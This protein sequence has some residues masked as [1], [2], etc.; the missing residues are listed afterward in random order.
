MALHPGVKGRGS[1]I[2]RALDL[3]LFDLPSLRAALVK[4]ATGLR[5][6]APPGRRGDESAFEV[7][8]VPSRDDLR[9]CFTLRR[10]VYD[11]MGYLPEAVSA[12]ASNLELDAFDVRA[13]HFMATHVP[14]GDLAGTMRLV[15]SKPQEC[16]DAVC[17][18]AWGRNIGI[19]AGE[20][21]TRF[22]HAP[23]FWPLPI[24]ASADF[25]DKWPEMLERAEDAAEVSRLI[26]APRYRGFGLSRLLVRAGLAKA[27][28]LGKSP[29]LLECIPAHRVLYAKFGFNLLTNLLQVTNDAVH[30]RPGDLDQ[31]AVGMYLD[32]NQTGAAT[33]ARKDLELIRSR[34]PEAAPP[35]GRFHVSVG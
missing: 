35:F 9:R 8:V 4:T 28:E 17:Q 23:P 33:L 14:T 6:K 7:N 16:R 25:R 29:L 34:A 12:N 31:Q 5:P 18:G 21:F 22:L 1:D 32:L 10:L 15:L 27:L 24:L 26:V 13:V 19:D 2:D 20:P 11:M 3:R 30:C